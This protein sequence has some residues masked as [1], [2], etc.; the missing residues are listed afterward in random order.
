MRDQLQRVQRRR[1]DRQG[2]P[3]TSFVD[4][5]IEFTVVAKFSESDVWW[6]FVRGRCPSTVTAWRPFVSTLD[7][8]EI[9][10]KQRAYQ[11]AC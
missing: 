7:A 8:A 10:E 1:Y 6:A 9:P 5:T 3:S 11:E 2:R 4:N